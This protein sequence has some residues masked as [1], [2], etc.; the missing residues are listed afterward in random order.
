MRFAASPQTFCPDP[1]SKQYRPPLS[2]FAWDEAAAGI[3][4]TMSK[5][6][7]WTRGAIDEDEGSTG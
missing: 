3:S 1:A 4:L 6:E 7:S 5:A 2:A